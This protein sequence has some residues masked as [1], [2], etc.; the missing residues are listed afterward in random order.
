MI[1]PLSAILLH[2]LSKLKDTR[3]RQ[4]LLRSVIDDDNHF[5]PIDLG[6]KNGAKT[7]IAEGSKIA[8]NRK[9]T[10]TIAKNLNKRN[11]RVAFLSESDTAKS[12]DAVIEY[13][14]K[15]YIAEFKHSTTTKASTIYFDLKNGFK[16]AQM[17]V[18]KV[19]HADKGHIDS[20]IDELARKNQIM[21]SLLL[22]N[23]LGIEMMFSRKELTSGSYKKKIKGFL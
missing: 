15:L 16:K 4:K 6:L 14:G 21:G 17:V 23:K 18:L 11:I 3:Q 20:I 12:A 7:T 8:S 2:E 13:K 9:N 10:L 22:V 1:K 5:K 19:T